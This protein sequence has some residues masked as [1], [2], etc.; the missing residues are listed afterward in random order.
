MH[1]S[2][3]R[4]TLSNP[5]VGVTVVRVAGEVDICT[6]TSLREQLLRALDRGA[7][8]LVIDLEEVPFIDSSGLGCLAG[9]AHHAAASGR[10]IALAA[11]QGRVRRVIAT[12]GLQ[13]VIP[14]HDTLA[15]ALASAG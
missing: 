13:R 11:P 15:D 14:V 10:A 4:I 3:F 1:A 12:T 6:C 5:R 9:A 2:G 8:R 7:R